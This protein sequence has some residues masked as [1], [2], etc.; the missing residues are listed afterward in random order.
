MHA[1]W[2][3][4]YR[5]FDGPDGRHWEVRE[6]EER[7]PTDGAL[8]HSLLFVAY[9]TIRRVRQYPAD[10]RELPPEELYRLSWRR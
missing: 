9:D 1:T 5:H 7:A 10:W 6:V 3:E 8:A 4:P 2:L